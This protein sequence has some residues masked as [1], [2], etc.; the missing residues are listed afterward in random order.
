MTVAGPAARPAS[1]AAAAAPMLLLAAACAAALLPSARDAHSVTTVTASCP[2]ASTD[3]TGSLQ[4]ALS[5][6]T[7]TT[8]V[9]P[10][11]PRA[12]WPTKPLYK[13]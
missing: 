2:V 12:V 9:I 11:S 1:Q 10:N 8:I 5:H 4:A 7:A 6:P 13:T 3:C